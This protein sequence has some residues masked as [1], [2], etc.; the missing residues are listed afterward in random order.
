MEM[1]LIHIIL[2]SKSNLSSS[3]SLTWFW[4]FRIVQF[5]PWFSPTFLSLVWR[6]PGKLTQVWFTW[7]KAAWKSQ[8]SPMRIFVAVMKSTTKTTLGTAWGEAELGKPIHFNC[9]NWGNP[10]KTGLRESIWKYDVNPE[11]QNQFG[12]IDLTI[13]WFNRPK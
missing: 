1:E 13:K 2:D 8:T 3:V 4:S 5:F 6:S 10:W 9:Q 12:E 7:G 11:T